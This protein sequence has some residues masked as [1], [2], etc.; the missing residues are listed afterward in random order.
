[1]REVCDVKQEYTIL[2]CTVYCTVQYIVLYWVEDMSSKFSNLRS[3][4]K[5]SLTADILMIMTDN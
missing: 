3:E 4:C 2:Y 1:M 5:C